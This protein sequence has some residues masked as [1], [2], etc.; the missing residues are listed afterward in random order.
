MTCGLL[1]AALVVRPVRIVVIPTAGF[2]AD[3]NQKAWTSPMR[4]VISTTFERFV[5]FALFTVALAAVAVAT[6]AL[7]LIVSVTV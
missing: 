6:V 4:H 7:L 5:S 1:K 3:N 2:V